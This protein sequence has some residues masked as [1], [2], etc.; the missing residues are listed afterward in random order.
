M[1]GVGPYGIVISI[2]RSFV[3][4]GMLDVDPSPAFVE[5]V[6]VHVRGRLAGFGRRMFGARAPVFLEDA[7][8]LREELA[9]DQ[10]RPAPERR[11]CLDTLPKRIVGRLMHDSGSIITVVFQIVAAA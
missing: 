6:E 5:W 10:G 7:A 9:G 3:A 4:V 8:A 1:L 2:V 11:C